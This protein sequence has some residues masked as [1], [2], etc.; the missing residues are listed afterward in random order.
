[1]VDDKGTPGAP[2]VRIFVVLLVLY[3]NTVAPWLC[4]CAMSNASASP[5]TESQTTHSSKPSCTANCCQDAHAKHDGKP[6]DSPKNQHPCP[7]QERLLLERP[8]ANLERTVLDIQ[9][10]FAE[11]GQH[12]ERAIDVVSV[13]G[14]NQRPAEGIIPTLLMSELRLKYHHAYLC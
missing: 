13:V 10:Y 5:T 8:S 7:I 4:C 6:T 11:L 1:M 9:I 12:V 3:S 14:P 2:D